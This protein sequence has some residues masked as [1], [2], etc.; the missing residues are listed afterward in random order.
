MLG[1]TVLKLLKENWKACAFVFLAIV[2]IFLWLRLQSETHR[3]NEAERGRD[4]AITLS[5]SWQQMT[6][7]YKN[8][9]GDLIHK[10]QVQEVD[11]TNL[12]ALSKSKELEWLGKFDGL[13]K[14]NKN[15]QSAFTFEST[16]F[17]SEVPEKIVKVPCKDTIRAFRYDLKDQWNDIHALVLDT[18]KFEIKDRYYGVIELK[19]PKGWFWKLQWRKFDP[20]SE[21]TNSNKLIKLDSIAVIQIKR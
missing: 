16:F 11:I 14:D 9:Y 15:L 7:V 12:K 17:G 19:R 1:L 10:T 2:V 18:P 13:K 4:A 21:I 5:N 3:A 6:Q 8:K 20:V